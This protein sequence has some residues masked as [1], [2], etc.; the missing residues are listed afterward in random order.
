ML[1]E[2]LD[3][4]Q[5]LD[6]LSPQ[7]RLRFVDGLLRPLIRP[8]DAITERY[9]KKD[10]VTD[11]AERLAEDG[12]DVGGSAGFRKALYSSLN[13]DPMK[14][15]YWGMLN[16][17]GADEVTPLLG[18]WAACY[19]YGGVWHKKSTPNASIQFSPGKLQEQTVHGI[20][21]DCVHDGMSYIKE[22]HNRDAVM[23]KYNNSINQVPHE[24]EVLGVLEPPGYFMRNRPSRQPQTGQLGLDLQ[25]PR[26]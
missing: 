5:K 24:A 20:V 3:L 1:H 26:T 11:I 4:D 19:F 7:A 25:L 16:M 9:L 10:L 2:P 23:G 18:P 6:H 17:E 15:V 8:R 22:T 13:K 21:V 12:V 14:R